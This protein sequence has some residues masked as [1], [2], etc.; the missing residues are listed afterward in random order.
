MSDRKSFAGMRVFNC[1]LKHRQMES[2]TIS[3]RVLLPTQQAINILYKLL[4]GGFV[5][6]QVN[7]FCS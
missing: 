1:L 2:R 6:I 5:A 4:R 3:D 7:I